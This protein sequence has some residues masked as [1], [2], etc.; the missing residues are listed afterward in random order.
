MSRL[1]AI[2]CASCLAL[3]GTTIAAQTPDSTSKQFNRYHFTTGIRINQGHP[4][5]VIGITKRMSNRIYEFAGA[6]LG[7][8][9]RSVS[10][11]TLITI[12]KPAK[13]RLFGLLG[14]QVET[15]DPNPT[16]DATISYLTGATGLLLNYNRNDLY[17]AWLAVQYLWTNADLKHWKFG[18]GFTFPIDLSTT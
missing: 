1:T 10:T 8:T 5:G 11:Y 17:T 15:V 18:I 7:G 6:D 4:F 14:P 9:Q 2:L 3:T 12:T 13:L 16:D